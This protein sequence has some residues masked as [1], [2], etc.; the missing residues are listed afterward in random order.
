[1]K[2][3]LV[4]LYPQVAEIPHVLGEFTVISTEILQELEKPGSSL[5]ALAVKE[6]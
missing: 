2:R 1:M 3:K 4:L 5:R 6:G